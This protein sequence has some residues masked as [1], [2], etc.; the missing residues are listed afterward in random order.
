MDQDP[1]FPLAL[2]NLNNTNRDTR[3][4]FDTDHIWE[5]ALQRKIK[6]HE[7]EALRLKGEL[8][9]TEVK[10]QSPD[11]YSTRYVL[12]RPREDGDTLEGIF[13][14]EEGRFIGITVYV[15]LDDNRLTKRR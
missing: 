6:H 9:R 10:E 5:R 4:V 13:V 2:Y 1:W 12:Q 3:G 8:V 15:R 7:V 14:I 11:W